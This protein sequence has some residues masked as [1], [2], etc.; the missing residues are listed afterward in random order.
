[1]T[2]AIAAAAVELPLSFPNDPADRIIYATAAEHGWRLVTR[3]ERMHA[4]SG[5]RGIAVW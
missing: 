1:M 4:L 3:D 5:K 2:P